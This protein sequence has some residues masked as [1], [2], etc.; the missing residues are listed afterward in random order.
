MSIFI[1]ISTPQLQVNFII[2][3]L[4]IDKNTSFAF[5]G[6]EKVSCASQL[7]DTLL[8][9]NFPCRPFQFEVNINGM[10]LC[11]STQSDL[12]RKGR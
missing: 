3:R 6:N 5:I 10:V 11:C 12:S 8:S 7:N 2:Y 4:P 1:L 9:G